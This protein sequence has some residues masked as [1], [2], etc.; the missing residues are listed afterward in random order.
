MNGNDRQ[1]SEKRQPSNDRRPAM[2]L[3]GNRWLFYLL[4]AALF[5]MF[6]NPFGEDRA[7][8]PYSFFKGELRDGNVSEILW[9]G[10][11][12]RG[13][14]DAPA[15]VP[16][17]EAPQAQPQGEPVEGDQAAP[18]QA[19]GEQAT[20]VE[21]RDG[22]QAEAGQPEEATQQAE[23]PV[24][25]AFVTYVPSGGDPELLDLLDQ[26]DV[27][28]QTRPEGNG[29]WLTLL[30]GALPILLLL[31]LGW[32]LI[33]RMRSQGGPG[34]GIFKVGE[35][36]AKLYDKEDADV[37]FA[38]VAGT[39]GAK[40]ELQETIS[41][42][43]DPTHF[44]ALGGR[45]PSGVLLM[46]PP[47]TGKTLLAK[48]V[49][50]ESGVPFYSTSGSDFMEMFVGV[51]ASRVRGMFEDAKENAPCIIFID[52]LDSIGRR[53][54]TGIG[55][56]HDER[57]Q[58]LN[59]LLNEMDGF[60]PNEK[61]IV[62]AATNRPDVLDP[63]LL[64]PG[65][66]DK[67]ITVDLPKKAAR[68]EILHIHARGKPVADDVDL[69]ALAR[70]TPGLSGADLENLLNEA[71]LHAARLDKDV[72]EQ[73]DVSAAR[74]KVLLGRQRE[75]INLTEDD[76][77]LIAV[78]EAGH[79]VLA[80]TLAHADPIEKVSIVP[81]GRAMGVTQQLP[82]REKY[83]YKREY[84]FDRLAVVM[85]GRAAEE[86]VL[87]TSTS[88]AAGDLQEGTKLARKMVREFGM[89]ERLGPVSFNRHEGQV[90][91]GESMAQQRDYSEQTERDIDEEVHRILSEAM[92]RA[93]DRLSE[94]RRALDEIAAR[95]QEDEEIDGGIV[96]ELLREHGGRPRRAPAHDDEDAEV[97]GGRTVA[98]D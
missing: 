49:A 73:D 68:L 88:G 26:Q 45:T 76:K 16:T 91:L 72:I 43:K 1:Q 81:R 15:T 36:Q 86:I 11:Q 89:S 60:E 25:D 18:A 13:T 79:A 96:L 40:R 65:R 39:E 17:A 10:Q 8:V 7:T 64:R 56:G 12:I 20:P 3:G 46:G 30:I 54:G 52:E 38:D 51:G 21:A 70:S 87:G 19:D 95:L 23:G 24:V 90:F 59:Q 66:F 84:L 74:D 62:M 93:R 67:E 53:R 14:L 33:R 97:V 9:Q 82:E 50:G 34:G 75:G 47:G 2:G 31:L 27:L 85:G 69:D 6:F 63:A 37:T 32:W 44:L 71:A 57:E 77:R 80:A 5:F 35:S 78:H 48:A 58:T 94:H 61:V 98:S 92:E 4:L 83:V 28:V 42:L 22:Q 41:F 29:L 55:G